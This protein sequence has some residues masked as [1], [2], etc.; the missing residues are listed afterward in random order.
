MFRDSPCH[1]LRSALHVT[2]Y[3]ADSL[4]LSNQ[5]VCKRQ[6]SVRSLMC[7]MDAARDTRT[8]A[9]DERSGEDAERDP[10]H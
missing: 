5:V 8:M 4:C 9:A 3:K 6:T 1:S 7:V 10:R 2:F